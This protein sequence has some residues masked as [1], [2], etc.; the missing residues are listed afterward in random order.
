MPSALQPQCSHYDGVDYNGLYT[1]IAGTL[2]C[3]PFTADITTDNNN[4]NNNNDN[5][6]NNTR[7]I[8]YV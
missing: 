2:T 8:D 5:N 1:H 4:N 6:N 7:S 3:P